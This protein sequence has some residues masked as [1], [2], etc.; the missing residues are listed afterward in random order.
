MIT[1]KT[2]IKLGVWA[3]VL[4]AGAG[5]YIYFE[6]GV[7]EPVEEPSGAVAGETMDAGQSPSEGAARSE[8]YQIVQESLEG[9]AS[10]LGDFVI[11]EVEANATVIKVADGD[12]FDA[13]L[14]PPSSRGA[15]LREAG[16]GITV[17]V[18]LLGVDTPETVDPRKPVQCFGKEAS[19]FT[20]NLLSG[21]RVR[22]DPDPLADERDQYGRVL[23]NVTLEDGTDVNAILVR[24]GYAHAYLSFPLDPSRKK[25]LYDLEQD[26]KTLERGMWAEGACGE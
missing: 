18:R 11:P 7:P 6:S 26:A 16:D 15:G 3:V 8:N 19:D 14:D 20:K 9:D 21:A 25:Q 13:A 22:L 12:T 23:R 17:T 1:K 10:D 24:D 4:L 5:G 2:W